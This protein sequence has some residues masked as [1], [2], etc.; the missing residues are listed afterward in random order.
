MST[1]APSQLTQFWHIPRHRTLSYSLSMP[2]FITTAPSGET[3]KYA[4]VSSTQKS[5]ERFSTYWYAPF[6]CVCRGCC[7]AEFGS[8]GGTYELPCIYRKKWVALHD[9]SNTRVYQCRMMEL[10]YV[11]W[12]L[13]VLIYIAPSLNSNTDSISHVETDHN[14]PVSTVYA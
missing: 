3:C 9:T 11:I 6:C 10:K 7:A 2:C 14:W 12:T 1:L 13:T 5:L 4:T 8:S